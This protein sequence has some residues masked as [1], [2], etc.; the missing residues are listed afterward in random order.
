MSRL[1][2]EGAVWQE[3]PVEDEEIQVA[4]AGPTGML[5]ALT[6][7]GM[8]LARCGVSWQNPKGIGFNVFKEVYFPIHY[9][10]INWN[11]AP[12]L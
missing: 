9:S 6:W 8:L 10:Y 5:W 3:I 12:T 11:H 2:P 7:S 4:A 1:S